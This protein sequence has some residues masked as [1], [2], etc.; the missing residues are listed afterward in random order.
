MQNELAGLSPDHLHVVAL[1]S[2]H[3][4][5]RLDG[6]R[7]IADCANPASR[8]AGDTRKRANQLTA[9]ELQIA[10]LA[11]H[12]LT[13]R[14][15]GQRLNLSHRTIATHLYRACPKLGITA[16]TELAAALATESAPGS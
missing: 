4:V 5:Q 10:Q 15:I 8:A 13:N 6:V 1:R 14:E 11:A 7:A 3:F 9:Q 2:G 16:G 12:G